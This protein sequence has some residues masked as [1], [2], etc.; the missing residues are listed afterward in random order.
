MAELVGDLAGNRTSGYK[1]DAEV[2][3]RECDEPGAKRHRQWPVEPELQPH[4]LGRGRVH[5]VV[6]V[7]SRGNPERGVS[8]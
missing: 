7:A 5:Q 4:G 1:R 8:G 6:A 3:S 2:Q